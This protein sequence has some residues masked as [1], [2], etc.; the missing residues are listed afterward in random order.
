MKKAMKWAEAKAKVGVTPARDRRLRREARAE[1]VAMSLRQLREEA[2]H[3]QV[4]MAELTELTQ[5][6]VSRMERKQD[7][8]IDSVRK[9]VE[10]LGG[11]VE[12]VAVLGNKRV[13]L[14]GV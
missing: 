6:T 4:E 7:N 3:T 8:P 11:E 9:Y 10:A 14:L 13:T 12:V 5:A 2:G 1:L